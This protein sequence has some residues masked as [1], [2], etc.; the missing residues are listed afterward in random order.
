MPPAEISEAVLMEALTELEEDEIP[1]K[2]AIEIDS[3]NEFI[4]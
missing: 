3:D 1:D 2:G 4:G